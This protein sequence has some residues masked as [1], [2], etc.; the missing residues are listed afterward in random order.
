MNN[1]RPRSIVLKGGP[2]PRV[3]RTYEDWLAE[4]KLD[5]RSPEERGIRVG[6]PIMW[7]HKH[8]DII[9][10]DRATV[11]AISDSTLTIQ[12]KDVRE[13]Q[14]E[15]DIS[16]VAIEDDRQARNAQA[17]AAANKAADE[18]EAKASAAAAKTDDEE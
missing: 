8:N 6:S 17:Q 7:R 2:Q 4:Q 9:V 15:I 13:H 16:E 10:T 11:I 5:R 14:R 12:V 18:A 3:Y 1:S